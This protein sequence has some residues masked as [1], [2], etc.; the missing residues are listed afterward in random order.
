MTIYDLKLY[1][2]HFPRLIGDSKV[3]LSQNR[4]EVYAKAP[5]HFRFEVEVLKQ[6][7]SKQNVLQLQFV[8]GHTEYITLYE[9][10]MYLDQDEWK[11][12]E[13]REVAEAF[14]EVYDELRDAEAQEKPTSIFDLIFYGLL[15]DFGFKT[16]RVVISLSRVTRARELSKNSVL[17]TAEILKEFKGNKYVIKAVTA[18]GEICYIPLFNANMYYDEKN[19]KWDYCNE[20]PIP[21]KILK[22]YIKHLN[23]YK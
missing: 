19:M 23:G 13:Y 5:R 17:F 18:E 7:G 2:V 8:S 6:Y 14:L 9:P 15:E 20:S 12:A 21:G 16:P 11:P 22:C 4:E 1:G 3:L 10:A